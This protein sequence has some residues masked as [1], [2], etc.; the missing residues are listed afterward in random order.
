M[1]FTSQHKQLVL[2][3]SWRSLENFPKD[4]RWVKLSDC[5]PRDKIE[6]IYNKH[7]NNSVSGAGNKPAPIIIGALLIKHK[8]NL[9]D[10]E[11]I[12]MISENP[13]M[14]Y[15]LGLPGFTTRLV[16]D[17]SLFVTIRKRL[18]DETFNDMNESILK[19]EMNMS[20]EKE[21]K[22]KNNGSDVPLFSSGSDPGISVSSDSRLAHDGVLKVD[23]TCSDAEV[24]SPIDLDLVQ[25]SIMIV[26]RE[27]SRLCKVI[28]IPALPTHL[29]ECRSRYLNAVKLRSKPVKKVRESMA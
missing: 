7:L 6:R 17:L 27:T 20:E 29:K 14:Q 5:L 4:N 25:G 26:D 24:R 22:D 11:T 28:N 9:S 8:M 2:Y 16:L 23:S 19:L 1:K 12:Q 15:M 13:Y 18:G 3:P 10:R 21:L